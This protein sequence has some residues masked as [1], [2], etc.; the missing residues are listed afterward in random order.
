MQFEER[1]L[2]RRA[3]ADRAADAAAPLEREAEQLQAARFEDPLK[4]LLR[5][6]APAGCQTLVQALHALHRCAFP[7]APNRSGLEPGRAWDGVDRSNGYE[8]R[9]LEKLQQ[10]RAQTDR[11]YLS[12]AK[13]L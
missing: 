6:D 13:H 12:H 1:L 10:L 11:D 9:Y 3:L 5:T 4:K 8:L 2:Q 7:A